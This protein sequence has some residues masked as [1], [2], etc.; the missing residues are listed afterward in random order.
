MAGKAKAATPMRG[1]ECDAFC[2]V[3]SLIL[4]APP[5]PPACCLGMCVCVSMLRQRVAHL[6]A[7]MASCSY[8]LS[9]PSSSSS[10]ISLTILS[11]ASA[12]ERYAKYIVFFFGFANSGLDLYCF[13]D[14]LCI[15]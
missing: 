7:I 14:N 1:G 9:S 10:M 12:G 3:L 11:P 6:A 8:L 15:T 4:A 5:P 2:A 13:P